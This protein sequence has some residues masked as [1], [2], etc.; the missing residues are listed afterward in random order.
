LEGRGIETITINVIDRSGG[1][2]PY[3]TTGESV[4][5]LS[6]DL[7]VRRTDTGLVIED[8]AGRHYFNKDGEYTGTMPK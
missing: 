1:G 7:K 3:R 2:G 8:A 6:D 4:L 5:H